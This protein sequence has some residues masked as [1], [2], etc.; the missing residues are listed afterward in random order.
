MDTPLSKLRIVYENGA[1]KTNIWQDRDAE[2]FVNQRKGDV[3]AQSEHAKAY[4]WSL[5]SSDS[6][7]IQAEETYVICDAGHA[8]EGKE[9]LL[10]HLSDVQKNEIEDR[11]RRLGLMQ[12][13]L[14]TIQGKTQD[15]DEKKLTRFF[16][17]W[18][19]EKGFDVSE[20]EI[21]ASDR[22]KYRDSELSQSLV[23]GHFFYGSCWKEGNNVEVCKR[24]LFQLALNFLNNERMNALIRI[25]EEK[26]NYSKIE[27]AIAKFHKDK[28]IFK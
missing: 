24:N 23:D 3:V 11:E 21:P 16:I 12:S 28:E 6:M 26:M 7:T 27:D 8:D 19:W 10:K 17:S 1:L 18:S 25:D 20:K 5:R 4:H 9:L 2:G 14:K 15:A 13:L 22:D